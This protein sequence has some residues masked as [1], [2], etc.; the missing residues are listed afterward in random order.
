MK[1]LPRIS[2]MALVALSLA[3]PAQGRPP[4]F[5]GKSVDRWQGELNDSDAKVRRSAAFALGRMG[6]DSSVA[7]PELARRLREDK[8]AGV[9]DMAASA[10]GDIIKAARGGGRAS[11]DDTGST[12]VS[13][14][15]ND[16]D[17]RVRRSAAFALGSFGSPA[18]EAVNTLREALRD[19]NA[20]VRQNA[21][22]ALGQIGDASAGAVPSLCECLNDK[23]AL[24]RRDAAGAL[25]AVGKAGAAGV[26][27]LIALVKSEPDEVV[28][29]TALEAL[30]HLAGPEH[31]P[32][33]PGLEPLIEAR[34]PEV[35]LNAALV[36]ARI[37]GDEAKRGLPALRRALKDADPH[38]Q[39]LATAALANLG[40]NAEPAMYDLAD[41]LTNTKNPTVVRRN[42]ALAIAHVGQAAR[43]V[44]SSLVQALK[45]NE[46]LEVRQFTA[47]ALA[48]LKYPANEKGVPAILE[49]IEKDTD[50]LVRQK[51]VWA[52]FGMNEPEQFKKFGADK[53]LGKLLD[54]EGDNTT[55]VRYDA[56]RKLANILGADAPSRTVDVLLHMLSN[57][58]LRVYN[59]TDAK[60]EGGG[61]EAIAG[62]ANV[63][64]NLGG[65]ARYMAAQA[66]SWM[67]D[68]AKKRKDV[69]EALRRA[70]KEED[71][72]LRKEAA[73][74]LDRLGLK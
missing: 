2:A 7:L 49:A 14:L 18:S 68:K 28:K 47:E 30:S 22:W 69:V 60:V 25:G 58:S 72:R 50:P 3:S 43:P 66:L 57:K 74:A 51:C 39:E 53:V 33:A 17:A 23:D 42:A 21:A 71:P 65:D 31:R 8:D 27:P 29:K 19:Q 40:P 20:S 70:A 48:Q 46:P 16:G 64:A 67:G 32:H 10:I 4:V 6:A 5:L 52:L 62:K 9:R 35:A 73:D 56:A 54:E 26:A 36:L 38:V 15:K 45:T 13:A 12:L 24:V 61:N 37:G 1:N 41:T 63:Q 11:W 59:R 34:D 44:V 55:L